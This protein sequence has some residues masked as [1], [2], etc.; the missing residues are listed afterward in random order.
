MIRNFNRLAHAVPGFEPRNLLSMLIQLPASR[1]ADAAAQRRFHTE[2]LRRVEALSPVE[3]AAV[4]N[5]LT[6]DTD[7]YHEYVHNRGRSAAAGRDLPG[8]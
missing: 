2:M 3:S 8:G 1:Y 6:M 5:V 4:V 7:N